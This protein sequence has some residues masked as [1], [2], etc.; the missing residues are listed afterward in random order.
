MNRAGHGK[1]LVMRVVVLQAACAAVVAAM[2]SM[3]QG[4]AAA[5]SGLVGGLIVAAG[6]AIFGWRLFAPGVA[7]APAL[8]RALFAAEALKWT[9]LVFAMW[10]AFARFRLPPLPLMTGLVFAQFGHWVGMLGKRGN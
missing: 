4:A 10:V 3:L 9:W 5:R 6:S 2:F 8:R 7:P 1:R